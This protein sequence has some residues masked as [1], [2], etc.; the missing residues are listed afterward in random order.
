MASRDDSFSVAWARPSPRPDGEGLRDPHDPY[1]RIHAVRVF[2]RDQERS[3]RFYVDKLG[4]KL[5]FD[6]RPESGPRWLAVAPPDGGT[7]L[8]LVAPRRGSIEHKLIGRATQVVFVT[9]DVP[10]KFREWHQKGVRFRHT[11]RLRRVRYQRDAAA[12]PERGATREP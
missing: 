7:V 9:E 6:A 4:F 8:S 5:A 11:P 1:L 3:L 10:A 2:V 12:E